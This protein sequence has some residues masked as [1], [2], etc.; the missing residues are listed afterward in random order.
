MLRPAAADPS[1]L[2]VLRP[3]VLAAPTA[4]PA[5]GATAAPAVTVCTDSWAITFGVQPRLALLIWL[6]PEVKSATTPLTFQPR[7]PARVS[8]TV[9]GL[10]S[11]GA[12]TS[13]LLPELSASEPRSTVAPP[14][15][16]ISAPASTLVVMFSLAVTPANAA[17]VTEAAGAEE[18]RKSAVL[19]GTKSA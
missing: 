12:D 5:P 19:L 7:L 15:V 14:A 3:A 9:T 11:F 13:R 10:M 17:T 2:A 16:M 6:L 4:I 18:A 8:V 1:R